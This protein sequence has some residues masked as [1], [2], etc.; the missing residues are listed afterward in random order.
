M[1]VILEDRL[2]LLK[3]GVHEVIRVISGALLIEVLAGFVL[4]QTSHLM[5]HVFQRLIFG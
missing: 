2:F 3:V 1:D 4:D 5:T